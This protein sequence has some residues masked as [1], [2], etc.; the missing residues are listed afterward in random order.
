MKAESTYLTEMS[1]DIVTQQTTEK[2]KSK[3]K[4]VRIQQVMINLDNWRGL[5]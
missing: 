2:D 4:I 5:F 3:S 1:F